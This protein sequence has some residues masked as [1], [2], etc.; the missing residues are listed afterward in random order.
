MKT[1]K[2]TFTLPNI[3]QAVFLP[4]CFVFLS[5]TGSSVFA[6]NKE[7][8]QSNRVEEKKAQINQTR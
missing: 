2:Y 3:W 1:T 4:F 6:Q 7:N 8:P 5:M